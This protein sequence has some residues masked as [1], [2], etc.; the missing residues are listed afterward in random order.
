LVGLLGCG[1]TERSPGTAVTSGVGGEA[2]GGNAG[3]GFGATVEGATG[4]GATGHGATGGV[5]TGGDA[6]GSSGGA[7]LGTAG[8]AELGTA[9]GAGTRDE[10]SLFDGY[11]AVIGF[12]DPVGVG[13]HSEAGNI[14]GYGCCAGFGDLAFDC[15]GEA[16]GVQQGNVALFQ[17]HINQPA[18]ASYGLEMVVAADGSRM[19]GRIGL[20]VP[21]V[22]PVA[23]VPYTPTDTQGWLTHDD[24]ELA[25]AT[26]AIEGGH[27]L[28]L[29]TPNPETEGL[30]EGE[31]YG[32]RLQGGNP[33]I[34]RSD[35]GSFWAGEMQWSADDMTLTVGPVAETEAM[36]AITLVLQYDEPGLVRV[37]ATMPSGEELLFLTE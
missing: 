16:M 1:Q 28:V 7:E 14:T 37:L 12:E 30:S 2:S 3:V 21:R 15:C 13:L 11:W 22:G 20:E 5:Q 26:Q 23:M 8:G 19:T 10:P 17:I 9:G 4:H 31:P 27:E 35:L 32:F 6:A 33:A 36:L 29:T 24:A 25:R 18:Y 34:L